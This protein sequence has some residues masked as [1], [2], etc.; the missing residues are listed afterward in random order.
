MRPPMLSDDELNEILDNLDASDIELSEDEDQPVDPAEDQAVN[1]EGEGEECDQDPSPEDGSSVPSVEETSDP[2]VRRVFW[3]LNAD[4]GEPAQHLMEV[5]GTGGQ[6]ELQTVLP[7]EM[8]QKYVPEDLFDVIAAC[9][10]QRLAEQGKTP[11][12]TP[13]DV[14]KFFGV[15]FYT[16]IFKYPWL[17]MYWSQKFRLP[18]VADP[19]SRNKF[20][21]I[22]ANLKIV[23]DNR[24]SEDHKRSDRL[25]K[26]RPLLDAIRQRCLQLDRPAA[27]AVDEQ[28]I[29]FSGSTSLKQYVPNKPNP[30][31][32]KN[33]VLAG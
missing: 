4:F 33:W 15:C 10:N 26:V 31:G 29:P 28:M 23:D 21:D 2:Q 7:L 20:F 30:V 22:R 9:T 16:S 13:G 19:L 1:V 14:F 11:N 3:R 18:L 17:R 25:W 27:A 24:V 12:I 6:T 32:L 8:F 5:E